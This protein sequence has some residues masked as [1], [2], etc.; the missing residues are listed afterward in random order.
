M[1]H[2]G[3]RYATAVV[4]AG[5][6]ACAES[7]TAREEAGSE[8]PGPVSD[9]PQ[10]SPAQTT[11]APA[12]LLDSLRADLARRTGVAAGDVHVVSARAMWWNDGSLGCPQ[13]G[14]AY[15][16]MIV[17]GYW[18]ILEAQGRQYDYRTGPGDAF[19]LC[20]RPPQTPGGR[21]REP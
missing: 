1:A 21:P 18:V 19:V 3:R 15:M 5:L 7:Q 10:P 4:I 11:S 14:M 13:P 8:N 17:D 9:E 2:I 16:Q 6:V 12:A 20:E